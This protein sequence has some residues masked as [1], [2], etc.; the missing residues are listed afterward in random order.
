MIDEQLRSSEVFPGLEIAEDEVVGVLSCYVEE[1]VSDVAFYG[2][3]A[4]VEKAGGRAD[5]CPCE[6][7]FECAGAGIG[8]TYAICVICPNLKVSPCLG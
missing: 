5:T 6:I 8:F 4:V 1:V 3:L 2:V 7:G